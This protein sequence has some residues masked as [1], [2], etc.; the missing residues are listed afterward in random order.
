MTNGANRHTGVIGLAVMGENLAL[1][2]ERNG[3]PIAVYNRTWSRTQ[4]FLADRAVGRDVTGAESIKGFVETLAKPRRIIIMVKAGA[5]VDAVLAELSEFVDPDDIVIDGGNSLFT[6]TE[7]RSVEW[8]GKFR[9]VG[10][11]ISGGEEGALWGPALMPGGPKGAYSILEPML[12]DISAK[13]KAGPCVTYIGPGGAGH[14]V[15]MVHNGIEYGDMQLIAETYDIMRHALGMSAAEIG[16]EF[17]RWNTGKLESFLIE[18]TGQ[19]LAVTDAESG[20]ALVDQILDTAEQKGT[21]RWT[22]QNALDLGTPIPTIDAA[23]GARMMSS[24]KDERIAA[25]LTL[26]GPVIEPITDET[27]RAALIDHLENA[28]YFAKISSYAQGMALL[29]SASATYGWDLNLSEIARIWMAGCIIR[30]ELLDP[31]RAAFKADP[32]LVN[33]LLAPHITRDVNENSPSARIAVETAVRNG[34][35]VPAF[36]ASLNYVDTY[37]TE[38]LPANLIQGLRDNFGAHTYRRLDKA[39]VFHTNWT[40]GETETIG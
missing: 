16:I 29:Q 37:R 13:S 22:S 27:E 40:T 21:G 38:K 24:R 15:K 2:I 7:R 6:D 17:E 36:T 12:V 28:L 19:V 14:Y 18:I 25:A 32:A 8:D 35:P 9:F 4:E 10:M 33:L 26:A 23:V 30:A 5:P 34:I 20:V 39:G 11:G 3:Y 31:I 1:N